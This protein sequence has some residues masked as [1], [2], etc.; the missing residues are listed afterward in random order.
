MKKILITGAGSGIGRDSAIALARRGHA[1]TATTENEFQ[2]EPLREHAKQEGVTLEIFTLNITNEEHRERIR[3]LPID[4]LINN[5]GIGEGGPLAEVPLERL[6]KVFETNVFGTIA[7]TQIALDHMLTKDTGT[8]L[9]VSSIAGRVPRAYFGPY[10]MTKFALSGGMAAM[11]SEVKHLTK[12]VHISIIEPGAYATGF[13]QR[14]IATKYE[15]LTEKSKYFPLLSVI[16]KSE[17]QLTRFEVKSTASIVAKIVMAA[18]SKNP[19]LRYG[20]PWIQTF[21]VQLARIVGL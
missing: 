8:V 12:N 15:W 13:N 20:A 2:N 11:R 6:R 17:S 3:A 9:I 1:V 14:M 4:V 19:K 18:E 10:G 21:F 16:R 5:A 7:L